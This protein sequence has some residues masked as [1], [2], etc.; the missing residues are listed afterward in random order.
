MSKGVKF[1]QPNLHNL[2]H[3]ICVAF[4]QKWW[5]DGANRNDCSAVSNFLLKLFKVGFLGTQ[6]SQPNINLP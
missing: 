3:S 4:R 6:S 2:E 5:P 1:L